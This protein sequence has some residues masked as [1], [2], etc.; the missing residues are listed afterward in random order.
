MEGKAGLQ[1]QRVAGA[2]AGGPDAGVE[3]ETPARGGDGRGD[4]ELDA[5]LAG[6][7][8]PGDPAG[9]PVED[10]RLHREPGNVGPT[11]LQ[12]GE[13]LAGGG[14][15]DGDHGPAR[16]DVRDRARAV[17]ATAGRVAES[18][19]QRRGVG[20]VGHDEEFLVADPP[21]DDVVDDV[22]IVGVE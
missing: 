22:R 1:A 7:P 14:A 13:L 18:S 11:R 6:V 3:Q 5:V 12:R 9:L 8:G 19:E 10:G 15:L 4:V 20:R 16:G 17:G 21:H 2:Q